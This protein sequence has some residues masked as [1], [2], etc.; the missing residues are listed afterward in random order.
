MLKKKKSGQI[1]CVAIP[2]SRFLIRIHPV[3]RLD[4]C[5]SLFRSR[6]L[7]R[8]TRKRWRDGK[9]N[10]NYALRMQTIYNHYYYCYYSYS[11]IECCFSVFTLREYYYAFPCD[12]KWISWWLDFIFLCMALHKYV[13]TIRNFPL[14]SNKYL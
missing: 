6:F 2:S 5:I 4:N 1:S 10:T 12:L 11:P 9:I 14:Q 13:W 7:A 3:L 8:S